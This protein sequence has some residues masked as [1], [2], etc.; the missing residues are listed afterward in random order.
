MAIDASLTQNTV[1]T[2]QDSDPINATALN[3][4]S[5]RQPF[6]API[7]HSLIPLPLLASFSASSSA[8][9]AF[10]SG[11]FCRDCGRVNVQRFLRHRVCESAHCSILRSRA[12][13][14]HSVGGDRL[15]SKVKE[16]GDDG[17]GWMMDIMAVRNPRLT[18]VCLF[19]DNMCLEPAVSL[20]RQDWGD[21]MRVFWYGLPSL[22]S[23]SQHTFL[24][25]QV[26]PTPPVPAVPV[27]NLAPVTSEQVLHS[28]KPLVRHIFTGNL[29]RLQTE[30]TDLFGR[31][32]LDIQFERRF[33]ETVFT[34]RFDSSAIVEGEGGTVMPK[35]ITKLQEFM[36]YLVSTYGEEKAIKMP[37]IEI[38]SWVGEGKVTN[39]PLT[40]FDLNT[41]LAQARDVFHAK[42]KSLAVLCLGAD[43]AFT[44]T[45]SDH[46][47]KGTPADPTKVSAKAPSVNLR[48]HDATSDTQALGAKKKAKSSAVLRITLLHGDMMVLSGGDFEA[49]G[50]VIR[51]VGHLSCVSQAVFHGSYRNVHMYALP[52]R[53]A[54]PLS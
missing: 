7:T 36:E 51:K 54:V 47:S 23:L 37:A 25:G 45:Y 10:P 8:N 49:S 52:S 11:Y 12:T 40:V 35:S 24:D 29:P 4:F 48:N 1:A 20:L 22:S 44:F 19:P 21:G 13:M 17:Q 42:G 14:G 6:D 2:E 39:L 41:Y 34:N 33:G 38:L 53:V 43:V 18:Y 32:Q 28:D 27:S 31:L 5:P 15:E 46:N 30:P 26:P 50:F 9:D 3:L 16:I